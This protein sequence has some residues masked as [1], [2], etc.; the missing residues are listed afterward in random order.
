MSD[1]TL[2]NLIRDLRE[3]IVQERRDLLRSL[4]LVDDDQNPILASLDPEDAHHLEPFDALI[5]RCN[6]ELGDVIE[7]GDAP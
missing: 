3:F 1:K 2:M 4:C 6:V 7:K 5:S